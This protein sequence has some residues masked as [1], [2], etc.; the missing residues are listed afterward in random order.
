VVLALS[1]LIA[2][3]AWGC[4]GGE[5]T[6]QELIDGVIASADEQETVRYEMSMVYGMA[7]TVDGEYGEIDVSVGIDSLVDMVDEEM[8]L[9]MTTTMSIRADTQTEETSAIKEYILG[10]MAYVGIVSPVAPTEWVKGDVPEDFWELENYVSQQVELLRGAEVE[11]LGTEKVKGISCYVAEI[12]PDMDKILEFMSAQLEQT[13]P[14]MELTEDSLSNYSLKGWYAKGT[15]FPMST[16]QE[17]DFTFE[18]GEDELVAHYVIDIS[19]YDYNEPV[20]IEL[21]PEAEEAEYVGPIE[22]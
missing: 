19:M 12:S 10:D 8:Q 7:G 15:F 20:S 5:I 17:F 13:L 11:I 22:M 6:G 2:A 1:M 3:A 18:V 4:G 14:M 21:P 16:L 9:D